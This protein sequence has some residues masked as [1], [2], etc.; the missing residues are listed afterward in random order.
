MQV[1]P[2]RSFFSIMTTRL[3]ILEA[4][5]AAF[6]PAGPLP[7]TTISYSAMGSMMVVQIEF[8][9]N[10]RVEVDYEKNNNSHRDTER[11]PRVSWQYFLE[12]FVTQETRFWRAVEQRDSRFDGEFVYAVQSTGVYC[13][14]SCPSRRPLRS[15]VTFFQ[16]PRAAEQQGF[17]AC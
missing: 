14:P 11:R 1:P 8:E 2:T 4:A 6:C 5:M 12:G 16:G 9:R 7:M 10:V 17:R 3:P 15:R 13:R